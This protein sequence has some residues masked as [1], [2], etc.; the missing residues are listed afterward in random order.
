MHC[1]YWS[2]LKLGKEPHRRLKEAG[3]IGVMDSIKLAHGLPE[4]V[5]GRLDKTP[6]DKKPSFNN[7]A[8]YKA[9]VGGGVAD[10]NWHLAL[11]DATATAAVLRAAE[12]VSLLSSATRVASHSL[13]SLDQMTLKVHKDACS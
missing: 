10:L 11:D 2:M 12:M 4:S 6:K 3:V 8:L 7:K 9:L 13:V 1:R 5:K